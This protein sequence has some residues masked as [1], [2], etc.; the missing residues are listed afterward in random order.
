MASEGPLSRLHEKLLDTQ[1][2][3]LRET[4]ERN[5]MFSP[6]VS[7]GPRRTSDASPLSGPLRRTSSRD[8]RPSLRKSNSDSE[9]SFCMG[10][11]DKDDMAEEN[12]G[13]FKR[14][15]SRERFL[16]KIEK[17][18]SYMGIDWY[19]HST[20][21][22]EFSLV[23]FVSNRYYWCYTA[24]I[25]F[26]IFL[27]GVLLWWFEPNGR[28]TFVQALYSSAASVSQSGLAVVNWSEQSFSTHVISFGLILM[29]SA[30]LLLMVPVALRR[31]AFQRQAV[32]RRTSLAQRPSVTS[33]NPGRGRYSSSLSERHRLEYKALGKILRIMI[34][35]WLTVHCLGWLIFFSYMSFG[36]GEIQAQFEKEGLSSQYHAAYLTVSAFQNN[37]LV[38]TPSSVTHFAQSPILLN[39]IAAL[40]LCGN[41]A[42][43]IMVR[44]IAVCWERLATEGTEGKE[45]LRFILQHPR[46][47]FTHMFPAVHTLWLLLVVVVLTGWQ[48]VVFLWED[49]DSSAVG[50]MTPSVKFWNALFQA[51]SAR[52]A[53]MNSVNLA[54]LSQGTTLAIAIS[55]FVATT[56]TTVT[57]RFSA[58]THPEDPQ[59]PELDITGRAEGI[60]EDVIQV[61]NSLRS[62]ARRYLTQDITYLVI[63]IFFICC[64]EK[65]QFQSSAT[66]GFQGSDGI[67]A[68]FTF[69]K[70]LF[71]LISAYGTC[72]LSLGFRNE[73]WSFSGEWQPSSQFLLIIAM[74]L[75]RLRGLPDSIDPSV[76]VAMLP[77]EDHH[78]HA[79]FITADHTPHRTTQPRAIRSQSLA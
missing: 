63:I 66:Q 54:Y 18:L 48:T 45:V 57:M 35:Y 74:I 17:G 6:V 21:N 52:T 55:M 25:N 46:R 4:D 24:Y 31:W 26:I 68:D 43:P 50:G 77:R 36:E 51:V 39:T 9:L 72:G 78:S 1:E 56:P 41:T 47:C 2:A 59:H 29:G 5:A 44:L 23:F 37:G 73:P 13:M 7:P 70:V 38:T 79:S 60:E 33:P 65:E 76:R 40:I 34:G 20:H 3:L 15:L 27:G 42:L 75:G 67:Y 8:S 62:Q 61:N 22:R 28:F 16:E 71:E 53:G 49:W 30:S 64:I 32:M 58:H 69:F 10:V 12:E 11:G 19:T 14:G